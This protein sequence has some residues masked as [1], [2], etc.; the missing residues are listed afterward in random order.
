MKKILG[1]YAGILAVVFIV[2]SFFDFGGDYAIEKKLWRLN[3]DYVEIVRDPAATPPNAYDRLIA[4][5]QKV[6]RSH[7]RSRLIPGV[8]LMIGQLYVARKDLVG[9]RRV[10][11]SVAQKYAKSPEVTAEAMA[12]LGKTYEVANDWTGA[13][14]IY[15]DIMQKYPLTAAGLNAPIYIANYYQSK[16]DHQRT[17]QAYEKAVD[18]Y[19]D[20][21]AKNPDSPAE[22]SALRFLANCYFSQNR[23]EEGV[24]ALGK[25]LLEYSDSS[26]LTVGRVE[27][28][29]KT[30]NTV[31]LSELERE[32]H[33]RVIK[34]YRAF[35]D[36]YPGHP[37][38]KTVKEKMTELLSPGPKN[39]KE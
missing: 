7:P 1:V 11:I 15:R 2:F 28:I 36:K 27:L 32:K 10:F 26:L 30:I 13:E 17:M 18:F 9:A 22:F 8:E 33:D 38:R 34:V 16:N 6:I 37:L 39:N 3:K 35:L 31:T 14:E 21:I 5:Y 4:K 29:A 24:E 20:V 12:N 25:V 19:R 23:W